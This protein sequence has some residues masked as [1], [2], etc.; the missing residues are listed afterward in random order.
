MR[1]AALPLAGAVV[2]TVLIGAILWGPRFW[3]PRPEI[4]WVEVPAGE[5]LMGSDQQV[6]PEAQNNEI[7]QHR[8]YLDAFRISEYEITNAQYRQCVRATVCDEP[9]DLKFYSSPDYDDHPVVYVSWFDAGSFCEWVGGRLPTEAEWEY[10]A[11][12]PQGNTYPWGE[13]EPTCELAQFGVGEC[14]GGM[15]PVGSFPDGASWCGALDMA[16]NVWEWVNDWY[17]ED[18]YADSPDSNP[19]GPETGDEKVLRGGAYYND[20][21]EV[22]SAYRGLINPARR[23]YYLG[24]RC[25]AASTP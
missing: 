1:R 17:Q 15:E 21:T 2:A 11:R 16:S 13:D 24:F 19:S 22:R 4:E 7:P 12:G 5:F 20:V 14:P 10:A 18:Y 9:G 25:V 23:E 8:V 3:T 6:D